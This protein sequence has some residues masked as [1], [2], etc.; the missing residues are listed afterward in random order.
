M[1]ARCAWMVFAPFE[2]IVTVLV[3]AILYLGWAAF[4]YLKAL[5][6]LFGRAVALIMLRF[7]VGGVFGRAGEKSSEPPISGGFARDLGERGR[8]DSWLN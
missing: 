1:L 2:F 4:I 8:L 6:D 3:G 7:R 5:R